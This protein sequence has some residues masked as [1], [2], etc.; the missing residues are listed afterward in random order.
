MTTD[1]IQVATV[2]FCAIIVPLIFH[3]FKTLR[4]LELDQV[5]QAERLE[6]IE[7][8]YKQGMEYLKESFDDLK[9]DITEL[10]TE[11]REILRN[12]RVDD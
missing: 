12:R 7:G 3:I 6:H 2:L 4:K 10:K 5:K 8:N 1:I 11:L 9:T